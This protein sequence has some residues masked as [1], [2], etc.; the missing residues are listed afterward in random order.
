MTDAEVKQIVEDLA[1][2]CDSLEEA[3]FLLVK[4]I[5]I[6]LDIKTVKQELIEGFNHLEI[7]WLE[8]YLNSL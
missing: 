7:E 2:G 8:D 5:V 4:L 3:V 6:G 1:R